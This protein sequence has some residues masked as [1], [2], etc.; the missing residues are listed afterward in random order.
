MIPV[1]TGALLEPAAPEVPVEPVLVEVV[2]VEP[3]LVE[4]AVAVP[5]AEVPV[6]D[7]VLVPEV[8]FGDPLVPANPTFR[9]VWTALSRALNAASRLVMKAGCAAVESV[10]AAE[11]PA[12]GAAV[13]LVPAPVVVAGAAELDPEPVL[14]VPDPLAVPVEDAA[15]VAAF[16]SLSR[17]LSFATM[18]PPPW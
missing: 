11:L 16:R 7:A 10:V 15:A 8:P 18:P 5:D 4:P 12:A 13:A 3:V 9:S 17:A 2:P 14:P 6:T 1:A